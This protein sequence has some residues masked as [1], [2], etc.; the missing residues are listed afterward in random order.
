MVQ[1]TNVTQVPSLLC[2]IPQEGD[3]FCWMPVHVISLH[4]KTFY[5]I[6]SFIYQ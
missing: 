5:F 3:L 4:W 2:H 1:L 6:L